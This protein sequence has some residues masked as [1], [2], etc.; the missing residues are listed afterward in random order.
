MPEVPCQRCGVS[1]DMETDAYYQRIP[2]DTAPDSA[3]PLFFCSPRC[4]YE[5]TG[6]HT[7]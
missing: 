2:P 1:I 6:E 3:T 5:Y 4:V 7:E